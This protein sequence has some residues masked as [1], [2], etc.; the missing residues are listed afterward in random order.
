MW[1][2][3]QM[4]PD[5][6]RL[7]ESDE[8]RYA[9]ADESGFLPNNTDDGVLW[10]DF[11]RP[12]SVEVDNS[13]NPPREYFNIPLT[14]R[15]GKTLARPRTC[16]RWRCWL[17]SSTGRWRSASTSTRSRSS[18]CRDELLLAHHLRRE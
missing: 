16:A 6:H 15:P 1:N 9:I 18:G 3:P 12:L 14:T 7:F 10:L 11:T 5:G 13:F 4:M 17:R 2:K 8:N